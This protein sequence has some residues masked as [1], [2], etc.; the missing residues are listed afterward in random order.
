MKK[1]ISVI[2]MTAIVSLFAIVPTFA[3]TG[4][5]T[6]NVNNVSVPVYTNLYDA[7]EINVLSD[8]I[9]PRYKYIKQIGIGLKVQNNK[10]HLYV[11]CITHNTAKISIKVELQKYENGNWKTI[12]TYSDSENGT[13][14]IVSESYDV[15]SGYNY[16]TNVTINANE[17]KITKTS[18]VEYCK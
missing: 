11:E 5:Q 4:I 12:K 7:E 13:D 15:S 9:M 1:K 3:Q 14:C 16:R 10:A 8:T 18:S 17:E 2:V 6:V